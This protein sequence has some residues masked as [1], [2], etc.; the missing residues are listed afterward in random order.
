MSNL[1][2]F[3]SFLF[4]VVTFSGTAA[5]SSGFEVAPFS[6][7][8]CE[9]ELSKKHLIPTVLTCFSIVASR[10]SQLSGG[11]FIHATLGT[12]IQLIRQAHGLPHDEETVTAFIESKGGNPKSHISVHPAA[13][14]ICQENVSV[15]YP[16]P[17][18]INGTIVRHMDID[19][20]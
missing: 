9:K 6:K 4:A 2:I 7:E 18:I 13:Y 15:S 10:P 12:V 20:N 19:C 8:W 16:A 5:H 11:S 3:F 14:K 17:T 1:L